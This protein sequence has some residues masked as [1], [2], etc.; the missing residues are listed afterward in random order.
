MKLYSFFR[1]SA[2]YRCRIA[3]NLK[4]VPH[5][6]ALIH[7]RKDGGQQRSPEYT[8]VNPQQLV[9][10]IEVNGNVLTQ[11]TAIIEWL[12]ETYPEPPFLP[13]DPMRRAQVRAFC[14]AIACDIPP[15]NNSRVPAYLHEVLG[16]AEDAGNGGYRH[17]VE[18]GLT[19]CEALVKRSGAL[20]EFCFGAQPGMAE[21]YLVPQIANAR[22][23]SC[24][25]SGC[26]TLVSI[27]EDCEEIP[28]FSD[29]RPG[30]QPD[31]E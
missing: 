1:S 10:A 28:A 22:R 11:S 14:N 15:L 29:A 24:D 19:A 23:F 9:P 8:A 21:I 5:D 4:G 26:P 6:M 3:L 27:A 18:L 7:L 16:P 17:W 2:A 25:L 20:D 12:E 31:A 13:A 30:A